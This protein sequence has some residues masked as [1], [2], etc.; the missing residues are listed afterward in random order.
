MPTG[1]RTRTGPL[2]GFA[3]AAVVALAG[4]LAS[5][6][7]AG[8][9]GSHVPV[10]LRDAE[11]VAVAELLR[12][13]D[14]REFDEARLLVA[15]AAAHPE[16]RR[17]AALAAGRLR[18]PAAVPMLVRLL[19]DRDTAV[20]ATAAFA[21]GQIGDTA[22][23][24]ALVPWLVAGRA[25]AAPTVAGEAAAALGKLRSPT[26]ATALE[27]FLASGTVTAARSPAVEHALLATWRH[28]RPADPTPLLR[29]TESPHPEVRW[30][31]VYAAVRRPT[32]AAAP[33][34]LQL[35]RD[36]DPRVRA[37]AVRGL[38]RALAD[39]AGLPPAAVLPV[40]LAATEDDDRNTAV[41]AA[42]T[43]GTFAAAES[44]RRL[45][46]MLGSEPARAVAAAESLGRLGA[47]AAEAAPTLRGAA[48]DVSRSIGVRGAALQALAQVALE[49]AAPVAERLAQEQD[50]RARAAAGRVFAVTGPRPGPRLTAL[51]R[52]PDPRVGAATLQAAV[53][54]A[55]ESI[56]PLRELLVE[57]L[58]APDVQLRTAALTGLGRLRDAATSPLLLD[59]F[60]R[61]ARDTTN[62]AALAALDA[63]HALHEGGAAG[64]RT[65]FQ[66]VRQPRDATVH[67]RGIERFGELA[68]AAWGAPLPIETGRGPAD[69]EAAVRRW[70]LPALAG[71][72]LPVARIET[73]SGTIDL[74]LFAADAPLTVESFLTLAERGYFDGQEW[75]RVVPNFVIQGGDPRGDQ[76]G[77]P[78]YAIR[79]ELNRHRYELGTLGMAL[80]GPDTGGSQFFLTHSAQPHLDGGYTVFGEVVRGMDVVDRVTMGERIARVRLLP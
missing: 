68:R 50:W 13:E 2:F 29:W 52:D 42:R 23:V 79:D 47:A 70:V 62:N 38:T 66:R 48:L 5:C 27:S 61:A 10:H 63:L 74:R 65:L 6:A 28:P 37:L 36:P 17:R 22:A 40:V 30:R 34:L 7:T 1:R 55:G 46:A 44:V 35:A 3:S 39:T 53:E 26:A 75:P 16:V 43:L 78:G 58:G 71:R 20:A 57:S 60:E 64:A 9:A 59:A 25:E 76:S 49:E 24:T 33:R 12:L 73:A 80:A 8:G 72:S 14:R 11:V 77:G 18:E 56:A 31:A 45:E 19:A 4:T 21:L 51:V 69:Y 67:L 41:N 54:A 15:A 32:P